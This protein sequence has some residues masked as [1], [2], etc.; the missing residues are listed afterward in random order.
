MLL[1]IPLDDRHST[2]RL[3]YIFAG[4]AGLHLHVVSQITGPTLPQLL[5]N[6]SQLHPAA[7]LAV[8]SMQ[9]AHMQQQST[10]RMGPGLEPGKRQGLSTRPSST[11]PQL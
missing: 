4:D 6:S 1:F 10:V 9:L 2:S 5:Q 3:H 7:P 8:H 11:P